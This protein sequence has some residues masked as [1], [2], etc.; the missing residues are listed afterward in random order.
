AGLVDGAAGALADGVEQLELAE[1]LSGPR[2]VAGGGVGFQAE[3]GAAGGTGDLLAGRELHDLDG[4]MAVR[5]EDMHG[6]A[7]SWRGSAGHSRTGP[8]G[9]QGW[10]GEKGRAQTHSLSHKG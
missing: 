4:V 9:L 6:G 8:P 7:S 10:A 3:A 1:L 5:A 2:L